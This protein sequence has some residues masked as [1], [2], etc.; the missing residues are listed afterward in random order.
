MKA[1]VNARIGETT[2]SGWRKLVPVLWLL[3]L[4]AAGF[5]LRAM[6]E[7]F[8]TFRA[9]GQIFTNVTVLNR[10]RTDVFLQHDGGLANVKVKQ[11]DPETQEALGYETAGHNRAEKKAAVPEQI[12]QQIAEKIEQNPQFQALEE[13]WQT[14]MQPKLPAMTDRVLAAVLGVFLAAYLFHSYCCMLIVKKTGN[15]PGPLIWIPGM[16]M[17]PMLTAAGM[18]RWWFLGLLLPLVSL[19]VVA[20]WCF[21]IVQ[22]RGKSMIWGVLLLLPITSFIAFL[23]LAFSDD[24][25]AEEE[26]PPPPVLVRA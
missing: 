2:P 1:G 21:K 17:L 9:G 5:T 16:Q 10:T 19:I 24:G 11:L 25:S 22:A 6:E 20:I 12:K 7:K 13:K 15:Q 3:L 18:S 23:Y 8:E 4:A 26:V 14:E